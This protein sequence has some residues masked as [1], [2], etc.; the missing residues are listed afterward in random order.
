[1]DKQ[2][3][4][5]S[6][7]LWKYI[8]PIFIQNLE[9]NNV[10]DSVDT[11]WHIT[12]HDTTAKTITVDQDL[13]QELSEASTGFTQSWFLTN[14][15]GAWA[16]ISGVSFNTRTI[17]YSYLH[18]SLNVGMHASWN[19]PYR[20]FTLDPVDIM[21]DVE[22]WSSTFVQPGPVWKHSDGTYRMVSNGYN[23]SY[24]TTTLYS[25]P[26]L[27]TWTVISGTSGTTGYMY[28]AGVAPFNESW[29]VGAVNHNT[30]GNMVEIQSGAYAGNY[31]CFFQGLNASSEMH[32]AAVIMDEDFNVVYMPSTPLVIPGYL[33]DA[34]DKYNIALG[35]IYFNNKY[36]VTISYR[37]LTPDNLYQVLF[38]ELSGVT[39]P[40]VTNI[41]VIILG[42]I[43][44]SWMSLDCPGG[45]TFEYNGKLYSLVIGE[46]NAGA[47]TDTPLYANFECGISS[48]NKSGVWTIN[49][50]SPLIMNSVSMDEIFP[51]TYWQSDAM[52]TTNMFIDN[53]IMYVFTSFKS[54]TDSYRIGRLVSNTTII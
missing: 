16:Y 35:T 30:Y 28:R 36:Y 18:G 12:A 43:P 46:N 23:G 51:G 7:T 33:V 54:G 6:N 27:E 25:S 11:R 50:M 42:Q 4:C 49:P 19:C 47:T 2:I 53:G 15:P 22:T 52:G 48:R 29:C 5:Y 37:H 31:L 41:E 17:S 26:D 24:N 45:P 20:N 3:L 32:T 14:A 21:I 1:M 10:N 38:C 9:R 13:P 8:K 34:S 39:D 44:N 40:T